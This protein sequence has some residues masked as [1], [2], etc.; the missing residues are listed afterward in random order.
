MGRRRRRSLL[1]RSHPAPR[2]ATSAQKSEAAPAEEPSDGILADEEASSAEA[3]LSEAPD[4]VEETAH[5]E[6]ASAPEEAAA[7]GSNE[8]V[9]SSAEDEP[10]A[11]PTPV[12][13]PATSPTD[14]A[15]QET[16]MSGGL[17]PSEIETVDLGTDPITPHGAAAAEAKGDATPPPPE[18]RFVGQ[19]E[20]LRGWQPRRSFRTRPFVTTAELQLASSIA[21]LA[22]VMIIVGFFGMLALYAIV[23]E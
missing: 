10:S 1:T 21:A 3:V 2:L 4:A 18:V 6:A 9:E 16:P 12:A 11:G 23:A 22:V 5:G 20:M 15:A 19:R 17:R 7:D 13:P 8:P 14:V